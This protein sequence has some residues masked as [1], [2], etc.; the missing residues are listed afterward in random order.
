MSIPIMSQFN[1]LYLKE[2]FET[3]AGNSNENKEININYQAADP[4]IELILDH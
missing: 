1:A 3:F 2:G 4:E